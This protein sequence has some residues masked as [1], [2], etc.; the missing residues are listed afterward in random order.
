MDFANNLRSRPIQ[1]III[2]VLAFLLYANTLLNGFLYDDIPQVLN[3]PWIKD[4]GYLPQIFF[5]KS[6]GFDP[7]HTTSSYYRPMMHLLFMAEY[8]IFSLSPWGWHLTNITFHAL[9]GIFAFLLFSTLFKNYS[10][11]SA[12]SNIG[13]RALSLIAAL[14]VTAHPARSE[15]VAWVSAIPELSFTLTLIISL[16]MYILYR[17]SGKISTLIIS[18]IF[19]FLSTL[20][21]ETSLALPLLIAAFDIIFRDREKFRFRARYI[22]YGVVI[23]IY[24]ALRI[25]ALSG[26]TPRPGS[27]SYLSAFQYFINIFPLFIDHMKT[28][29]VPIKLSI[30]HVFHP[31]YSAGEFR[32]IISFLVT[33]IIFGIFFRLRK[34]DRLYIFS[35]AL[36][37]LPLLPALYI[38]ALD[39]NPF[40]ERYLYLPTTGFALFVALLFKEIYG[41]I[42][43]ENK[44]KAIN[45]ITALFIIIIFLYSI[46]T[47]KRNFDWKDRFT[48]WNSAVTTDPANFVA[49][50]NLGNYHQSKNDPEKAAKLFEAS[51]EA[52]NA[53]QDQDPLYLG[54]THLALAG[55][56]S[57]AGKT[58]KAIEQY[59]VVLT[60]DPGRYKANLDIAILYHEKGKLDMALNHYRV[61]A[62]RAKRP[63]DMAGILMNIGN[64]HA[65]RR[66]W[67][68][69]LEVYSKALEIMPDD[70]TLIR[71]MD[72]IVEERSKE[73]D[74]T[75]R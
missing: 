19:F 17:E 63:D 67:N 35:F 8:K 59:K 4:I 31:V 37:V 62:K 29:I 25:N 9:N 64:I 52:N 61:A 53:L 14:I 38:P 24:F 7:S 16:Y 48:L 56:Y 1:V 20:S 36:I 46:A 60:M 68:E 43:G 41:C 45:N 11:D 21:K 18:A 2:L 26:L 66:Q 28:L 65:R 23:I 15:V 33:G 22:P 58:N 32:S 13:G 27:H 10:S 70:P 50:S 72:V 3:N 44:E 69:A 57:Q 6:W 54:L 42:S 71:N 75:K 40:A 34:R 51:L 47:I 55:A 74:G 39:R 12:R 5:E 49:L 30:Y 73:R